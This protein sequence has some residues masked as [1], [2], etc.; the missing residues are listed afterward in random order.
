MI[1]VDLL[2]DFDN[3]ILF[4]LGWTLHRQWGSWTQ[5]P[6][7]RGGWRNHRDRPDGFS[8]LR[9]AALSCNPRSCREWLVGVHWTHG[10]AVF[11][12]TLCVVRWLIFQLPRNFIS[13]PYFGR[14]WCPA[15]GINRDLN[16]SSMK[17]DFRCKRSFLSIAG[18][19]VQQFG[20][21]TKFF[22]YRFFEGVRKR[23]TDST[24]QLYFR[25]QLLH[26][27][28]IGR[29]WRLV[30]QNFRKAVIWSWSCSVKIVFGSARSSYI[31]I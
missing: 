26:F 27:D 8:C 5:R 17:T 10:N 7:M 22:R 25:N 19:K 28:W 29:K 1:S 15:P 24:L 11:N 16:V 30:T 13:C 6:W 20:V 12:H 4:H 21:E 14:H 23:L 2:L 9:G 31:I 3:L 18:A